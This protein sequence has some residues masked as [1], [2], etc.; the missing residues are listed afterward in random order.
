MTLKEKYQKEIIP[1]MMNSFGIHN[2]ME[3]PR[4]EKIIVLCGLNRALVE[5]DGKF[6]DMVKN[7]ITKITGQK[8]IEIKAKK[9]IAGFKIREG[10]SVALM[11]SMRGKRMYDFLNKLINVSIPRIKDFRGLNENSVDQFGNFNFGLKEQVVF[12]EVK[13]DE[14]ERVH[15]LQITVTTTARDK[16]KGLEL[17]KLF[18]FPFKK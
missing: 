18:G 16:K 1:A 12:P 14:V 7:T 4:V 15:G 17:F 5:Q 13:S 2:V 9:S 3:V 8:P 6:I 11:V 10:Q